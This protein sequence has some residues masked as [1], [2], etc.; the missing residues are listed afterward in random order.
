MHAIGGD[1]LGT[2][3]V[4]QFQVHQFMWNHPDDPSTDFEGTI[5]QGPHEAHLAAAIDDFDPTLAEQSP[6]SAR[7]FL[8]F[9]MDGI[10]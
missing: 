1:E 8:V 2:D 4:T 10:R 5:C 9:W 7:A 6:Q 3:C